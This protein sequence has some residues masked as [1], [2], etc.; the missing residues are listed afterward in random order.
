MT[1]LGVVDNL[2]HRI[3]AHQHEDPDIDDSP[4]DIRSGSGNVELDEASDDFAETE[5]LEY[6][7]KKG[8]ELVK[9]DMEIFADRMKYRLVSPPCL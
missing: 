1:L 2:I 4:L 8:L 7:I 5:N 9:G 3:E 6:T